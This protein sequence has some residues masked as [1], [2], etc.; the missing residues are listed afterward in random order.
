MITLTVSHN[1]FLSKEQR[2]ALSDP[3]FVLETV[4]VSVPV[5]FYEGKTSEPAKEVFC[6]YIISITDDNLA[7]RSNADGYTINLPV[8][9]ENAAGLVA[10]ML[11]DPGDGCR[12]MLQYKEYSTSK[13]KST[14]FR[15]IHTVEIYDMDALSES[16]V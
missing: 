16:I 15:V 11:K 12:G 14:K 9:L 6:K 5:W 8:T 3:G 10:D 1:I 2:Y 4:G 7:I 13:Y